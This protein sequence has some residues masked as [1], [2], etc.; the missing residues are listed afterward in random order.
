MQKYSLAGRL[1]RARLIL[2]AATNNAEV[3]ARL[4]QI[5]YD[6]PSIQVAQTLYTTCT[7]AQI[8]TLIARGD[9]TGATAAVTELFRVVEAR[10]NT[11]TQ[12]AR[13]VF[14]HDPDAQAVLGLRTSRRVSAA[15]I[16]HA[17]DDGTVAVAKRVRKVSQ[18][19]AAFLERA[20]ILY[21]GALA[22]V[23][24]QTELAKV[25]YSIARLQEERAGLTALENSDALQ[26]QQKATAKAKTASQEAAFEQ[27][28][29]W[30]IR[31]TGIV[32]PALKDRPDLLHAMGLK[33]RGR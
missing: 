13:V 12:I 20:R 16:A 26:E 29:K 11:L 18:S 28:D 3:A 21:D 7:T 6:E 2:N 32:A 8:S 22:D 24:V 23:H 4:A 10:A 5:G 31:F 33:Q 1:E 9:K 30:L 17:G 15:P 14:A 25:G 27:L 19:R